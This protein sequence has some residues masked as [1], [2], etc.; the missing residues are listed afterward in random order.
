MDGKNMNWMRSLTLL[1]VIGVLA[2]CSTVPATGTNTRAAKPT[3]QATPATPLRSMLWVGNSFFYYN[4]S[5]HGHLGQLMAGASATGKRGVRN[6]SATI[7]GSGLNWHDVASHFKPGGV[8]SY[9][10]VG[11]NEVRFNTFD[12]P[13][14]AVM[15][16]DCSQCPIHPK[17]Q[18][19]FHEFA[20][21]HSDTVRQHGAQ[22]ILFMSWAYADKP[23][24]TQPLADQY[25]Q[26]GKANNALVVPAGLAFA[27]SRAQR[28]DIPLIMADKRHPT[29]QGTYLGASTVMA[30]VFQINPMGSK[31]TA[32]LPADVA[33]HLQ[34]VAW[35]TAQKYHAEHGRG[36]L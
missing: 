15:M 19:V 4:N 12:K 6:V 7:S 29:L 22:P 32:G 20:K 11:D 33:A 36:S 3:V 34:A 24:M 9:S 30:S 10:F 27:A 2:A 23:D 25:T 18:P 13:F 26:A 28:P 1:G 14:D 17:L 8:S 16:M 35:E 31:Y 21:K 5:M